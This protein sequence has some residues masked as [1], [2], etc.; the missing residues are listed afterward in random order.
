MAIILMRWGI[1]TP[2]DDYVDDGVGGNSSTDESRNYVNQDGSNKKKKSIIME[3][4]NAAKKDDFF[5]ERIY[6]LP[7]VASDKRDAKPV[8]PWDIWYSQGCVPLKLSFR[9]CKIR[10]QCHPT[11]HRRTTMSKT[12]N[13][14]DTWMSDV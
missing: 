5:V 1:T 9:P 14:K 11:R 8:S 3:D 6:S 4:K 12:S 13:N 7:V 2:G 10:E